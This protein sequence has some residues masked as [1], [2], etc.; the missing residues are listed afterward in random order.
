MCDVRGHVCRVANASPRRSQLASNAKGNK[1]PGKQK[2]GKEKENT[3]IE[4]KEKKATGHARA[5]ASYIHLVFPTQAI[6]QCEDLHHTHSTHKWHGKRRDRHRPPAARKS[7]KEKA[8]KSKETR[9]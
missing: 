6:S 7:Q 8:K 9:Y 2:K 3:E 4:R 1:R 5:R